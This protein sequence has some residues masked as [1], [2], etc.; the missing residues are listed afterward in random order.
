MSLASARI[1]LELERRRRK[2]C[3]MPLMRFIPT[4]TPGFVAPAHLSPLVDL[5]EASERGSVRVVSSVPPQHAKS[6]TILHALVQ[7]LLR[8]P[9]TRHAYVTYSIE[10]AG[11]QQE[12]AK[13]IAERARLRLDAVTRE[14]WVTPAGGGITWTGVGGSITGRPID[15][16]SSPTTCSRTARKLRASRC[17]NRVFASLQGDMLTR[18]HPGSSVIVNATR[19]HMDDPSG[20]LIRR[21]WRSIN[22][23]AI[24]EDGT[25]LWPEARPLDFLERQRA[26]IGEYDWHALYQG[27]PRPRGGRVF[28]WRHHV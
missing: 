3:A 24:G 11:D 6:Q 26:D 17:R 13:R 28:S 5:L 1:E 10:F 4:V 21:G 15:G 9:E 18:L 8:R 7:R 25:A 16:F 19:Y 14:R 2:R 20:R 12:I 22:L 27:E 23:P